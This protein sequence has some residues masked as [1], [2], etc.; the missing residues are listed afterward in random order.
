MGTALVRLGDGRWAAQKGSWIDWTM[1][2]VG[3][4]S[5]DSTGARKLNML[6]SAA[7]KGAAQCIR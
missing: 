1:D 2:S 4:Q 5:V 6:R 7:A 3:T